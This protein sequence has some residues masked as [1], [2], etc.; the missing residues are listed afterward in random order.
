MLLILSQ[1]VHIFT[2]FGNEELGQQIRQAHRQ[3]YRHLSIRY[4]FIQIAPFFIYPEGDKDFGHDDVY[5]AD[6]WNYPWPQGLV[7]RLTAYDRALILTRNY[8]IVRHLEE[9][10][11]LFDQENDADIQLISPIQHLCEA[12]CD[13]GEELAPHAEKMAVSGQ[14]C[15]IG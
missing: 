15:L 7:Q 13:F 4:P 5:E 3:N 1:L 9:F 8:D 10:E 12:R 11:R 14:K 2:D 6:F